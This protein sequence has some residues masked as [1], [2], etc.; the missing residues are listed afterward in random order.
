[1]S[2]MTF[3][4]ALEAAVAERGEDWTYPKYQEV[5]G[6]CLDTEW[7]YVGGACRYVTRTANEPACII[8]LALTKMG[9]TPRQLDARAS[10]GSMMEV[11][12]VGTTDERD[13]AYTAQRKQDTGGT[14]GEA[15]TTYKE[16]LGL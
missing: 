10:A 11:L 3:T 7:H 15:L 9:F 4:E 8:G 13:A 16:A 5:P 1:M 12:D 14:W 6:S 2:T